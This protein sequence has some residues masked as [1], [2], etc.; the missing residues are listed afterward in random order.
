VLVLVLEVYKEEEVAQ[1]QQEQHRH[2][3]M[4]P[5]AV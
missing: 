1:Y 2:H 3:L 5:R 4:C